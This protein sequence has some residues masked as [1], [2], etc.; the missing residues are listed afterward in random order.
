MPHFFQ[1][2]MLDYVDDK[3]RH[4]KSNTQ[5]FAGLGSLQA[6]ASKYP[7][8]A[9]FLTSY[10]EKNVLESGTDIQKF[11]DGPS[12]NSDGKVLYDY[13]TSSDKYVWPVDVQFTD[14][15]TKWSN[16]NW[17]SDRSVIISNTKPSSY[18]LDNVVWV[19]AGTFKP[20]NE[21]SDLG[22][23]SSDQAA[24]SAAKKEKAELAAEMK[25]SKSISTKEFVVTGNNVTVRD[26]PS[27]TGKKIS[28]LNKGDS[29]K[30]IGTNSVP[31]DPYVKIV[32]AVK[33]VNKSGYFSTQYLAENGS[34]L[35]IKAVTSKVSSASSAKAPV[36]VKP[37]DLEIEKSSN[38]NSDTVKNVVIVG[39]AVATAGLI[40]WALKKYKII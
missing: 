3:I 22:V 31:K 4:D 35:A 8:G 33:G 13:T 2:L 38:E 14:G 24:F 6:S 18:T 37:A 12:G 5:F 23:S 25:A 32:Y 7:T 11:Y 9:V 36:N 34:S 30:L 28:S 1:G 29:V 17:G 39:G 27:K 26:A 21:F 20:Y 16:D 19:S 40:F 15:K 10:S